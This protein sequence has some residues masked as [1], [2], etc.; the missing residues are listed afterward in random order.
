MAFITDFEHDQTARSAFLPPDR[1]DANR[2]PSHTESDSIVSASGEQVP[3]QAAFS[4]KSPRIPLELHKEVIDW[5]AV[6][7]ISLDAQQSLL[8]C[9]LVCKTWYPLAYKYLY[10]LICIDG[11]DISKL[12]A[13]L[14]NKPMLAQSITTFAVELDGFSISPVLLSW[15]LINLQKLEIWY[16][17]LQAE[18]TWLCRAA[19][20]LTNVHYVGLMEVQACTAASL[21]RF[22]NSFQS[23]STLEILSLDSL[24]CKNQPLP[25]H[26]KPTTFSLTD[27]TIVVIPGTSTLLN[28]L[29]RADLAVVSL[30]RLS[31][32]FGNQTENLSLTQENIAVFL[33]HYSNTLVELILDITGLEYVSLSGLTKLSK[34][35]YYISGDYIHLDILKDTIEHLQQIPS[36]N[37][38]TEIGL[39]LD[40][41][42]DIKEDQAVDPFTK[43][44]VDPDD[45]E[46]LDSLLVGGQFKLLHTVAMSP[47]IHHQYLPQSAYAGLLTI[48]QRKETR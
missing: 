15:N 30:E 17:D 20:Q 32:W 26:R 33:N 40:H 39:D 47:A 12:K 36:T 18:S 24:E 35:I 2:L 23:L 19:A 41:D 3:S 48:Y 31:L 42:F 11:K 22:I 13:S 8:S 7:W 21:I 38:I 9:M 45:W 37:V 16:L 10:N 34:L 25:R 27:L 1:A 43:A 4:R 29:I 14:K 44:G 28:W 5:A 46:K 6:S